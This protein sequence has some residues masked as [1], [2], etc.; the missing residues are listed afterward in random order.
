[1]LT[2]E[3][4]PDLDKRSCS[5]CDKI[6]YVITVEPADDPLATLLTDGLWVE[7]EDYTFVLCDDCADNLYQKGKLGYGGSGSGFIV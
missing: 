1:M 3:N 7:G 2:K 4:H 5:H 6:V